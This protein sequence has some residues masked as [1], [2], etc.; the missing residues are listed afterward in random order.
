MDSPSRRMAMATGRNA[1]HA[2]F[3]YHIALPFYLALTMS[4]SLS[5]SPFSF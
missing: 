4:E 2:L 3:G 1:T 5:I